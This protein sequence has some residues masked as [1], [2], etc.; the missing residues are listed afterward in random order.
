MSDQR[1]TKAQ[2]L[3]ELTQLR[4]RVAQL[5]RPTGHRAHPEEA[6]RREKAFLDELFNSAPEA[7]VL[8]DNAGIV[9]RANE[10]FTTLFGY[11]REEVIG[12]SIDQLVAPGDMQLEAA[13]YTSQVARGERIAV[14]TVRRRKDGSLVDVSILGVPIRVG[15]GQ[16]AVY[17]IYRG[18]GEQKRAERAL[19]ESEERYRTL[20]EN[21]PIGLGVADAHGN[22]LAFNQA[23]LDPGGWTRDEV[24]E[25]GNVAE[26]YADPEERTRVLELARRQ[27]FVRREE[28]RFRRQDGSAYDALLSLTPITVEGRSGWHAMVED[29]TERKHAEETLVREKQ[30]SDITLDSLPG[31]FY[32]MDEQ[33]R[34]L[35]WN[36]NLL[37]FTGYSEEELKGLSPLD[38]FR[39]EERPRIERSLREVFAAGFATVE[40]HLVAKDGSRVPYV[41]TALRTT[42][43]GKQCIVGTAINIT[44]RRRV[45]DELRRSEAVYR[46]LVDH[47]PYGIYL[48]SLDSKLL[49]VN[50]ALVD[51]LGYRSEQELLGVSVQEE[52]CAEPEAGDALSARLREGEPVDGVEMEWRRKDGRR[53]TV[54]LSG[55]PV[56]GD[57]GEFEGYQMIAEDVTERRVLEAQLRQ[58]QKMEAIGQLTGGIAHDFNNVL[59]VI[60]ANADLV[61]S[62]LPRE[63]TQARADLED[64][65][66]AARRGTTL[67][68]KL[69]GFSRRERLELQPTDLTQLMQDLSAMLRRVVPENIEIQLLAAEPD[70]V[71]AADPGAIE[72]IVL[73]L[74]TNSRD[75]M[76]DGGILRIETSRTWL[77][78]GYRATHPWVDPGEYIC[79]TC[80]DTGMGMDEETRERVFEPFFTTKPPGEG[81]GLG[82]AMIYGLVKQHGG[83]VHVY[84]DPGEGTTVNVYFPAVSASAEAAA[85]GPSA[86]GMRGDETILLVEDEGG[87]RRATRRALEGQGYSVLLAADGE[88][89]L[90]VFRQHEAAIDL[91]VSDLVMPRLG[92]RQFYQ[93]LKEQGKRPRILFTSGYS[94]QDVRAGLG[95]LRGVPFLHKPWTLTDLFLRVREVLEQDPA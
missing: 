79:L 27:G 38:F 68:R 56:H 16:V 70:A 93:A 90:E 31:I 72:Q 53:V 7:V 34:L 42:L 66:G 60:L 83:Y 87:I 88:E 78:E 45:E 8:V 21:A 25:F 12:Q 32:L 91:I 29:I 39:E 10:Y 9:L 67:I 26:L 35:R 19:R 30:F 11:R 75:A 17:G 64:I 47:A 62:A 44:E 89:A 28:V 13:G 49:S 92:G 82:M 22:L 43:A 80:T 14:E 1:K 4:E 58:A 81:T 40:A 57:G 37:K 52:L 18:I 73:N 59:T 94:A 69:L 61:V 36:N 6:L 85:A 71:A 55:R 41:F 65:Q 54:R 95:F 3:E 77:D 33:G 86:A 74:A 76:P 50:P 23:I 20:F 48:S 24:R 84:S 46:A 2:L 5:E 63:L 15:Q 51:M